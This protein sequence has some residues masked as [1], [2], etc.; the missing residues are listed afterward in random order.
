MSSGRRSRR[1]APLFP[2]KAASIGGDIPTAKPR[3][4]ALVRMV[5]SLNLAGVRI[6][7]SARAEPHQLLAPESPRDPTKRTTRVPKHSG[8][9]LEDQVQ[10]TLL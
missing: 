9:S 10:P 6:Q 1:Q 2:H 7:C 4:E 3:P 8:P 5:T